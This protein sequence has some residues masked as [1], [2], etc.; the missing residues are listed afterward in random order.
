MRRVFLLLLALAPALAFAQSIEFPPG[1]GGGSGTVT[2]VGFTGG[3]ISVANPT[4]TPALTVAGTSGG[5]PYFS[6]ASTWASSAALAAN[7]LMV[8]GGAGASPL[9]VT[10]GAGVLTALAAAPNA[11]GGFLTGLTVGTTGT[12]SG[13]AGQIMFDTGSVLTEQTG[14]SYSSGILSVQNG[15]TAQSIQAYNTASGTSFV[16]FEKAIFSFQN[17]VNTLTIGTTF[18][19]TGVARNMQFVV[20]GV[21]KLDYG[22]TVSN[23]WT[24]SAGFE[25]GINSG[26]LNGS[27]GSI[28]IPGQAGFYGFTSNTVALPASTIDTNLS[29]VSAGIIGVGTGALGSVAGSIKAAAFISASTSPVLTTGSCSGSSAAGGA[30]AGTFV[31]A[32]CT[33]GTYILSS[34]PTAP[35]G[36]ACIAQD[37]TT[38]ANLLQ[39][40]ASSTTSATFTATTLISDVVGFQCLAY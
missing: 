28:Y 30:S 25:W 6:G 22:I 24:T 38:P 13:A 31:A 14:F 29:R 12:T 9:T 17:T 27:T 26:Y 18:G 1:G 34:M 4:T 5:I 33:G 20:G 7:S 35:T 10:T 23:I 16:N 37:R 3:L 19:G 8:G 15:V 39:Q 32:A 21:N 11:S 40:T 2:S 36:Y